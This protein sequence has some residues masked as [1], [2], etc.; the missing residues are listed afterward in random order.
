MKLIYIILVCLL[1][2]PLVSANIELTDVRGYV[3]DE[4]ETNVDEDGGELRAYINDIVDFIVEIE[5]TENTTSQTKLKLQIK[6]IDDGNDIEKTQDWYDIDPN[7]DRSK[8]LTFTVPDTSR[9]DEYDIKL[10]VWYKYNNGTEWNEIVDYTIDVRKDNV[11]KASVEDILINMTSTCSE[12]TQNLGTCF[13]YIGRFDN[14]SSELSDVK[15]ERGSYNS[16]ATDCESSLQV[17]KEEK[18][19]LSQEKQSC[20]NEKNSMITLSECQAQKETVRKEGEEAKN[21]MMGIGIAIIIGVVIW[22]QQK[23]KKAMTHDDYF[24]RR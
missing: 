23:K 4:R 13:G 14:C 10:T 15:E 2:I 17:C 19:G 20:I 6:D 7:D 22:Q 8:I 18:T 9:E 24:Q 5:N 11:E 3:N 12:I 1:A 16:R 21:M